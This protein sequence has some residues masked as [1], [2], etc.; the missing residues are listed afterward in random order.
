M[1]T[2]LQNKGQNLT[3]VDIIRAVVKK[4]NFQQAYDLL[5]KN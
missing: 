5:N 2:Q 3:E 1:T 4:R